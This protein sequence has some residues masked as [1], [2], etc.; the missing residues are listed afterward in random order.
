MQTPT[1]EWDRAASGWNHYSPL[2]HDWLYDATQSMLH[3]ARIRSGARV[4]DIA[5]GAG[6]QTLEIAKRVGASGYVLA[7]DI[8]PGI[9]A[10]ALENART[11]GFV[12]VDARV[13][14]AQSL[15]LAG[16]KFDAAV[17]RLGLMFCT[18]PER[19]LAG[20]Y[21]AL[22]PG[23]RFSALV[24]GAPANNPI[25]TIPFAIAS[26]HAGRRYSQS[27]AESPGALMSLSNTARLSTLL[28]TTGFEEVRVHHIATLFRTT[29]VD[30]YVAFL[31]ASASPLIEILAPLP[32]AVQQMAWSEI[33]KQLDQY[34]TVQGWEGPKALL[35]CEGLRP[36]SKGGELD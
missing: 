8:A 5:A 16:A 2:I 23:A 15:N 19:A 4:L 30:E 12:Q 9:L 7:T 32:D 18:Q 31:R 6:D 33:R 34:S 11:A 17:C 20:I 1:C 27:E 25:L 14:D 29:A 24:F 35:L 22:K 36:R 10:Y 21:T 3:A 26:R 28:E 13:A